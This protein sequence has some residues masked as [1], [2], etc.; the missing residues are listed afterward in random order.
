MLALQNVNWDN[1]GCTIINQNHE[2]NKPD[3]LFQKIE[4]DKIEEQLLKLK[5]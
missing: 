2:L 5:S 4:D 3:H 1:A